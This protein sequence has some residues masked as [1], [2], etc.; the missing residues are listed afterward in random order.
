MQNRRSVGEFSGKVSELCSC[1][2]LS[3]QKTP[4]ATE[5]AGYAASE[6]A[7]NKEKCSVRHHSILTSLFCFQAVSGQ[8]AECSLQPKSRP[9]LLTQ[10]TFQR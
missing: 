3:G 2:C 1:A 8:H 5:N 9:S 4:L 10:V 6:K 7:V